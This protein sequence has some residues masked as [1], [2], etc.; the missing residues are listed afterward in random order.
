VKLLEDGVADGS[1]RKLEKPGV[2][3]TAILGSMTIQTLS[4]IDKTSIADLHEQMTSFI[5][6]GLQPQP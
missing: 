3:A 4:K 1:L 5:L 2:V 6:Q